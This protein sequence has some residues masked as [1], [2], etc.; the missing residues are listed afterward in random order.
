[1]AVRPARGPMRL[2]DNFDWDPAKA[3]TNLTKHGVTFPDAARVLSDNE[4]STHH[5][6]REDQRRSYGE[7]RIVTL[8]TDPSNRSIVLSV[9]WTERIDDGDRV[10]RIISAR[11]ASKGERGL[12]G[13]AIG[14]R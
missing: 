4:G 6:E 10:T 5:V 14:E 1:L 11:R 2:H 13:K 8:G 7:V 9:C 3:A 12:Y